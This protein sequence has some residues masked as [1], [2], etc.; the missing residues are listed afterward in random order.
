RLMHR[1]LVGIIQAANDVLSRISDSKLSLELHI[2]EDDDDF[3]IKVRD[4]LAP[5]RPRSF[6]FISGGMKFRVAVAMAIG[7]GQYLS[8]QSNTHRV[9]MLIIDEGF[10]ALDEDAFDVMLEELD[11]IAA[12]VGTVVIVTHNPKVR[13]AI[14]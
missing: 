11:R 1:A 14:S 13:Q 5:D 12:D 8:A 9:E 10:G 4:A 3:Q 6:T 7:I 2:G